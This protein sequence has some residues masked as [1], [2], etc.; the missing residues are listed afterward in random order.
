MNP[1]EEFLEER[2]SQDLVLGILLL[3][4]GFNDLKHLGFLPKFLKNFGLPSSYVAYLYAL[5]YEDTLRA[6]E[7]IPQEESESSTYE[8]F[9]N[10]VTQPASQDLPKTPE[11][12][13]NS[14]IEISSQVLGCNIIA[15]V[16]NNNSALFIAESIFA[17]LEA[18]LA[19]SLDAKIYPHQSN[20]QLQLVPS[21]SISYF[22]NFQIK[23]DTGKSF[24]EVQYPFEEFEISNPE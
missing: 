22:I 23:D 18:F 10:W 4:T 9:I 7:W 1:R 20:F 21:C 12:L 5:G 11:F 13:V 15:Q 24:I 2:Q 14:E 6:E 17:P 3:R 19:T 8:L 16:P